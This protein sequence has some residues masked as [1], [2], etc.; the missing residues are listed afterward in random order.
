MYNRWREIVCCEYRWTMNTLWSLSFLKLEIQYDNNFLN[1]SSVLS[2]NRRSEIGH[3]SVSRG[4]ALVVIGRFARCS[5][6]SAEA[7]TRKFRG[8]TR[9]FNAFR[10]NPGW[11]IASADPIVDVR[12][13]AELSTAC[14]FLGYTRSEPS[15]TFS[16]FDATLRDHREVDRLV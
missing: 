1:D 9:R 12:A 5:A 6:T 13:P 10:D 8:K 3:V 16:A 7:S 11:L 14:T 15:F 2:G 4:I